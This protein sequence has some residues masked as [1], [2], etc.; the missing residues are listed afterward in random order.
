MSTS[1]FAKDAV[2]GSND[3]VALSNNNLH[4]AQYVWDT[5]TL[6]WIKQSVTTESGA[7]ASN[8]NVTNTSIPVTQSGTWTV[9]TSAPTYA[10]RYDSVDSTTSYL[11]NAAVGSSES[12]SVWQVQKL[13]FGVDGDVTITWA[14]G[15]ALF[16]NS[17]TNRASLSYS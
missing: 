12:S 6:S 2:T 8:V 17:W 15:D 7:P 1:L 3:A 16:N 13:V 11:G 9:V 4:V 14:D 10:K 5:N